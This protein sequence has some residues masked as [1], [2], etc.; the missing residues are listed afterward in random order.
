M[1]W[2]LPVGVLALV[3]SAADAGFVTY[4]E[5]EAYP[6]KMRAAYVAGA[7]DTLVGYGLTA[8]SRAIGAHYNKCLVRTKMT[9]D[10]LAEHVKEFATASPK[11]QSET[12]QY[13]LINYL[14][15]MC[16]PPPSADDKNGQ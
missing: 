4:A 5:W 12:V 1:R 9:G 11:Y 3:C 15:Q 13:A 8:Q 10:Q 2:W 7:F 14:I 16:G 6:T